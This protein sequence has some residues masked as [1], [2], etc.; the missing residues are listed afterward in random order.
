M[1]L[2]RTIRFRSIR[3]IRLRSIV[4]L[5]RWR[6]IRVRPVRLIRLGTII[7]LRCRRTTWFR[8]IVGLG[9]GR[10]IRFRSIR[11][12]W[13]RSIVRLR[14]WRTIRLRRTRRARA[15]IRSGL[16]ARTIPRLI[17]RRLIRWHTRSG[18]RLVSRLVA[19]AARVR[20]R[21]FSWRRYFDHGMRLSS[22]RGL[23]G[24]QFVCG[25]WN[26]RMRS[27]HLLLFRKRHGRRRRR[28]LSY[29]LPVRDCCRRRGHMIGGIGARSQYAFS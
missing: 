29:Y 19:G 14:R 3:L 5:C 24:S 6:T 21:R 2:W 12:I 22:G 13:L 11:L 18:I 10:T 4:R 9:C 16:V 17:C 7:W 23:S 25:R 28:V 20:L 15:L 26:S 27:H 8:A 1:R